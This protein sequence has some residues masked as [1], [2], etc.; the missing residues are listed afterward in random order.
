MNKSM[1]TRI[2]VGLILALLFVGL[3]FIG[4]LSAYGMQIYMAVFSIV[5]VLCI[6]EMTTV[7]KSAGYKPSIYPLAVMAALSPIFAYNAL[8]SNSVWLF[9]F[10]YVC[11]LITVLS[12]IFNKDGRNEDMIAGLFMYLYPIAPLICLFKVCTMGNVA[13]SR[14]SMLTVFA[15]P[16]IGDT[17]AYFFGVF[18]GKRKLCEHISPKKP[19]PAALAE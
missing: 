16:L 7:I 15:C 9:T 8:F 19:L 10:T 13:L 1:L 18:F 12:R 3:W 5:N 14:L 4:G 11:M 2:L 6:Y 17:F